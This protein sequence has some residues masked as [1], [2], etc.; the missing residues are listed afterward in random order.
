MK[1]RDG[2][3]SNSS[4]SSYIIKMYTTFDNFIDILR[5][6]RW[7]LFD[8]KTIHKEI[9]N[10]LLVLKTQREKNIDNVHSNLREFYNTQ[11]AK[12]EGE[13]E[14]ISKINEDNFPDIVRF[15]LKY[16]GIQC[17]EK[18]NFVELY[19]FTSMHNDYLEGMGELLSEIVL[20]M[21]F[22]GSCKIECERESDDDTLRGE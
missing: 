19:Y 7:D 1:I 21:L 3:V 20:K 12:V 15:I 13:I 6:N 9:E 14:E 5:G 17:A 2:F 18:E 16:R 10:Y 8:L 4:S 11:I 22:E